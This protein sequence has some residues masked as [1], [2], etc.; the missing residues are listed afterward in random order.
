MAQLEPDKWARSKTTGMGRRYNSSVPP[1]SQARHDMAKEESYDVIVVG[2]GHNGT[3]AAA[4]LAKCGLSVCLP[5]ERPEG[6]G[7]TKDSR[8]NTEDAYDQL[9]DM[10]YQLPAGVSNLRPGGL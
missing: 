2:V 8:M 7:A 5:E 1:I 4:C 10:M 9:A 3:T 6:G